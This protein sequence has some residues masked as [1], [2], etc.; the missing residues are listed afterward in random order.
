[1]QI[2]MNVLIEEELYK[3]F[4]RLVEEEGRTISG[5]IRLLIKQWMIDSDREKSKE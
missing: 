3:N 5:L 2:R 4:K 1:M